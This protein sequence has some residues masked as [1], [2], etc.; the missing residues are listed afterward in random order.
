MTKPF[1][2]W[3]GG[4]RQLLPEIMALMPTQF[5]RYF[6]PFIGGGAV[7]FHA[8]PKHSFISDVNEELINCYQIVRDRP[9]ELIASL[10]KH[11]YEADYFYALRNIDRDTEIFASLDRVER[12]SRLIYLNRTGFNGMYRVNKKGHFNVPFGRYVNPK[13]VNEPLILAASSA[14]RDTQIEIAPYDVALSKAQS[15]DFVY[16][17]P[18][19]MP[20]SKTAS[21]TSYAK[22]D[23]GF[24]KQEALADFCRYL[25]KKQVRFIASNA[26]LPPIIELYRGFQ[27]K[28]IKARRAIN[29]RADKRQYV[30][31]ILIW[32]F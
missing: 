19:Y 12:A 3:A 17:D 31:E 24:D 14:L 28:E 11:L 27:Q 18:P 16:L 10:G 32:N 26:Y 13:I 25:D 8:Q 2:K 20:V 21:F 6:E 9:Q 1:L 15:D 30:S 7:F 5:D 22:D 4:K 23:F 29:S